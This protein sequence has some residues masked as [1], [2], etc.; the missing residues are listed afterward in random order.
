MVVGAA[1]AAVVGS[2]VITSVTT[3]L[4]S[5]AAGTVGSAVGTGGAGSASSSAGSSTVLITQVQMLNMYGRIG[6]SNASEGMRTLTD[7]FGWSNFELGLRLDTS[8]QAERRAK[9]AQF[10][11]ETLDT[12]DVDDEDYGPCDVSDNA[13]NASGCVEFS[14][15][16]CSLAEVAP[17]VEKLLTCLIVLCGCWAVRILLGVICSRSWRPTKDRRDWP[18]SLLFP[19]WEAPML[20]AQSLPPAFYCSSFFFSSAP[21]NAYGGINQIL[22]ILRCIRTNDV[23]QV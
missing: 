15:D 7:G 9:K 14:G 20:L 5:A 18:D 13:A 23:V 16:V 21:L 3:A 12:D 11:S 1:L 19:S 17:P 10:D 8:L 6:G 2:A 4:G 22:G